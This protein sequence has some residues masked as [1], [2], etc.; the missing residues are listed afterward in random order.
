[1]VD[2]TGGIFVLD[3]LVVVFEPVMLYLP[4]ILYSP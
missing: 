3:N 1:V 4:V 2:S